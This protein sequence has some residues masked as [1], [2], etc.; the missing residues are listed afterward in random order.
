LFEPHVADVEWGYGAMGN[1]RWKGARL[2]DILDRAGLAK[3]SN[4]IT[5]EGADGPPV[6]KTHC[7]I[8]TMRRRG[9]SSRDGRRPTG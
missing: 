7:P 9:S 2:K 4:E 8:S 6:E 5:F 1:A 3:D